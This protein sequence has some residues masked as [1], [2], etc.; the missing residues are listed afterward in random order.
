MRTMPLDGMGTVSLPRDVTA[1]V[2]I[3]RSCATP[4]Y[5]RLGGRGRPTRVRIEEA[6]ID[7]G[8]IVDA[9]T[10]FSAAHSS[11]FGWTTTGSQAAL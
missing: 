6:A 1:V 4:G 8:P 3:P 11:Q 2:G 9:R 5:L 7:A 10:S